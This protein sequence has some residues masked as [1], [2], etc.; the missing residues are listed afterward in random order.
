MLQFANPLAPQFREVDLH[1]LVNEILNFADPILKQR[2]VRVGTRLDAQEKIVVGDGELLKQM[3]LNLLLNSLQAMPSHGSVMIGTR[4]VQLLPGGACSAGV[5]LTVQDT[6]LGIPPENLG[7]IFDPFF[8]T[9]KNGTGL[10]LSV[11]HQIVEQH[12]GFIRVD[13][14]VGAGTTFTINL[15]GAHLVSGAA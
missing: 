11:V 4:D 10:G 5:E 6:G 1:D 13:S 8:T 7:R 2:D 12:S 9:N 15:P 3:I 14:K